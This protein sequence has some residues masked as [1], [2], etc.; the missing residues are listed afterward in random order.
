[1]VFVKGVF[2]FLEYLWGQFGKISLPSAPLGG[3][4]YPRG[5]IGLHN[6]VNLSYCRNIGNFP[7]DYNCKSRIMSII[8]YFLGYFGLHNPINSRIRQAPEKKLLKC[9]KKFKKTLAIYIYKWYNTINPEGF[10]KPNF[11]S[12]GRL[13]L[14]TY[15][16]LPYQ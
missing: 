15:P 12:V 6:I 11:L 10:R 7:A 9:T 3:T 4:P 16:P 5:L 14:F 2:Y 13:E 1:M 8:Y